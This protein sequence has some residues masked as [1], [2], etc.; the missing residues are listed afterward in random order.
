MIVDAL[1]LSGVTFAGAALIYEQ[2]PLKAKLFLME[3]KLLTRVI[4]AVGTYTLLGGSVTAL[5]AA[6]FLDLMV[7]VTLAIL[8]DPQAAN[9]LARVGAYL[10]D[11]KQKVTTWLTEAC[12]SLPIPAQSKNDIYQPSAQA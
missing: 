4:C 10:K 2:L 11:L 1:V 5:F 3:H 9:N 6:G 7:G 8:N 12:A